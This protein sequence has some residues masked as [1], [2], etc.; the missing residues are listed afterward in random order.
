L[1]S[2]NKVVTLAAYKR[3]ELE[4]DLFAFRDKKFL[5]FD[6][7]AVTTLDF[8]FESNHFAFSKKGGQ[9]FM[10]KPVFSLAP[11]AK[12]SDILSSA[13]L[14]EARSFVGPVSA[15]RR[16][17]LGL[18]EPLLTLEFKSTAASNKIIIG[19]KDEKYY[20]LAA[21]GNEICEISK[22]FLEKFGGDATAFREKKVAIFYA[23][24]VKE[25]NFKSGSFAFAVRKNAD[26][27]WEFPKKNAGEKPGEEK[28]N[29]LLTSLA[30][31]EA[32]EF[33]DAPGTWPEFPV[34]VAMKVENAENPGKFADI[35][36]EFSAVAGE[37][38]LVRTPQLPYGF[39]VGKEI[40]EK[41]PQKMEDIA[42]GNPKTAK[43]EE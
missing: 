28:V 36:M 41:F 24:D 29:R 3:N 30:D 7:M 9:W 25:L 16:R 6:N 13:S 38:V 35:I 33:V 18:E 43:A 19:R 27:V 12:I 31:C 2:G 22:D 1:A 23:F 5:E 32:K 14:L 42:E 11:E 15:D 10:D 34:R 20:A 8:R 21:G 39:K 40:L 26:G 17:E 37:T 4:K